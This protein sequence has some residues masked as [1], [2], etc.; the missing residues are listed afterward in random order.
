MATATSTPERVLYRP[1]LGVAVGLSAG[2][3]ADAFFDLPLAAWF[4]GFWLLLASWLALWQRRRER[5][6]GLLLILATLGLG[7]MWHHVYWNLYPASELSLALK[8]EK[9]PIALEGVVA[10]YPR[11]VPAQPVTSPYEFELPN[12]W[13]VPFRI[14]HVRNGTRWETASGLTEVFVAADQLAIEPGE[15]IRLFAQANRPQPALN[16]GEFDFAAWSRGRRRRIFLRAGFAE[17]LVPTGEPRA[18]TA[19]QLVQSARQWVGTTLAAAVPPQQQGLAETIFLGRRERLE[20]STDDAFKQTGTVHLLALSGLHLGILALLAHQ[21]LRWIPAPVW[22]PG[23]A[24]LLLT[25]GY[26]L[27]VDARPPI[28]RAAILVGMVCAGIILYRRHDF[29][30]A[31]TLAWIGVV[32]YNPVE[33]FQ[34]GTQLSFVAVATLAWLAGVQQQLRTTDP[35]TKLIAQ[36][37]PWPIKLQRSL[38]RW[39]GVAVLASFVVWLVTLPL[40]LYHFHQASP[41]TILLSPIL[42]LIMMFALLGILLLLPVA[43]LAPAAATNISPWATLPL[44]GL[45]QIVT[46]TQQHAGFTYW[47]PG[48]ALWWVIGFYAVGAALATL[49]ICRRMPMR[50]GVAGLGIWLVIGFGYG[51]VQAERAR[52]RD[53]LVCTF[54]SVGHG[55]CVLVE[56]PGGQNLLY[57]CGRLGSPR[58]AAE[59][60][61]AV[62]WQKGIGHLD[63]VIVS[64]DDA[65]HYN[66]LPAILDRFSV[67]TVYC[68][69]FVQRDPSPLIAKLLEDIHRRGIPVGTLSAGKHLRTGA[70]VQLVV[71]HPTRRGVLGRD[72]ANS[73]VLLLEYAGR[74]ILL[75]GDLESPGT[76]AVIAEQPLDCDVVMAPHHGS[77]HSSP[78]DFY[79]WCQPE[80]IVVSSGNAEIE[81]SADRQ[82]GG[83]K[84]GEKW[85][86]TA[87]HG[88]VEVRLTSDGGP[89]AVIPVRDT[90]PILEN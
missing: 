87:A 23:L 41:W 12:Q 84:G 14:T 21:A 56:L 51:I 58:R 59:S 6:S 8:A 17:C 25:L 77:R 11:F 90:P 5:W 74:R 71:L 40:V 16:E 1:L 88:L 68:W 76:D 52:L 80:W 30:N 22:F 29:W 45:Q 70:E 53:D 39:I 57:D 67:G 64:H 43:M 60:L 49:L 81:V 75:P 85:L 86:C 61:S 46:L 26:V 63:G 7:G 38:V 55:T 66:G 9:Q 31:L 72:N 10:D 18:W 4:V 36:T 33:L 35:L 47:S 48:P 79:A 37:R 83:E 73:I 62:L 44:D 65:D 82:D 69:E 54:V 50:W 3:G 42:S 15:S 89:P 24:L 78:A 27:L 19:W 32:F 20:D 28:I 2:V 34:A 13:K